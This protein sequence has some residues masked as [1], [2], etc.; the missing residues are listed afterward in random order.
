MGIHQCK[1]SIFINCVILLALLSLCCLFWNAPAQGPI[2]TIPK[3]QPPV[4]KVFP[5]APAEQM[6][7][8]TGKF[9]IFTREELHKTNEWD[10]I[11]GAW[12]CIPSRPDIPV[13][14]RVEFCHSSWNADALLDCSVRDDSRGLFPRYAIL[15]VDAGNFESNFNLYDINYRTWDV[16]FLRQCD[17][18]N[19]F[20]VI[21][22]S[23][24]Y[25]DSR[26]WFCLNAA[27]GTISQEM[28]FIP[29]DVADKFWLVR[30]TNKP[31]GVWS[32]DRKSEKFAGHFNEVDEHKLAHNGSLLSTDGKSRARLLIPMPT[33]WHDVMAGTFLL[34]R[35]GQS[36]DIRVPVM[37][38]VMPVSGTRL[39]RPIG[40]C[41]V[42]TKDGT[43]EF[44][45]N[46][47]TND[48][49]ER[50]WSIDMAS[51]K[52][53]K[54]FRPY[55]QPKENDFAVFDGVPAPDYLRPYLK[56][57]QHFGRGGLAVAFLRHQGI[58]KNQPEFPDC[59]AGVSRDGRHILYKAK[60][61]PLAN[62]LIYGDLQT[63]EIVR[64][65]SP[66]RTP[67]DYMEFVWVETP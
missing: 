7:S 54:S 42:F 62:D 51:G 6:P 33:D 21:N 22:N 56:N 9:V 5:P 50:V 43:V 35:D 49:R 40:T 11:A 2:N 64:W 30:K 41:L 28:S 63:K 14:K 1:H 48:L 23:I 38:R 4:A 16:R 27:T 61:G 29:V 57:L 17:R 3:N 59:T 65:D 37:M 44:S 8:G 31:S 47:S 58:L 55:V 18:L 19:A 60:K 10:F 36:E 24:Y 67:G 39:L 15:Q 32:Y 12:E 13:T 52:A 34:Q 46:L 45:A 66:A 20:G 26:D 53:S 25:Q